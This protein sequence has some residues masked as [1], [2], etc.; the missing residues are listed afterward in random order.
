M[1]GKPVKKME[2]AGE[3]ASTT[4]LPPEETGAAGEAAAA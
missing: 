3:T 2:A 1:E 4:V